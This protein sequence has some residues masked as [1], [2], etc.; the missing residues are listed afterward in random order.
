[1]KTS[2][3]IARRAASD[4]EANVGVREEGNNAGKAVET[5]LAAVGLTKGAPWCAAFVR[6]RME[7]AAKA[8]GLTLPKN[9]PDSGWTP[10]YQEYAKANAV[11]IPVSSA[12]AGAAKPERGDLCCFYFPAKG[13]IAHIGIVVKPGAR[14]VYTVEGNTGP[15]AGPGVER[16]GDGVYRKFRRWAAFGKHG[17]FVR[18]EF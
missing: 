16:E 17:G 4:A 13:R 12:K 11:W 7:A 14:G 15:D 9:F 1:M 8:L 5:Y 6:Y 3:P 2:G 18:L 10:A